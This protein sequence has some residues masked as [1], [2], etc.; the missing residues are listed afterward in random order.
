MNKISQIYSTLFFIGY[1]KWFPGT[2]GSFVS[3][4]IIFLLNKILNNFEFIILFIFL[5]I[6]ATKLIDIYS[7][8]INKHDAKEIIIDEF[9]GIYFV[10]IFSYNFDSFNEF[11]KVSLIFIIF[12]ILDIFK[13][14]P[15]NWIDSNINNSYGII[16][17]DIIAGIYTIIIL[18][19]INAFI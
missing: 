14:Y 11:V 8:K 19:I 1:I 10:I 12:R 2:V 17:D 7:K 6:L 13:P 16:L 4:I 5:L 9:L 15:A 18:S 3:I